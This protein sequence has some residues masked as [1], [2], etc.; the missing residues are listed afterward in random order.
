MDLRGD[1]GEHGRME[2][3]VGGG[4]TLYNG[5]SLDGGSGV[6]VVM[7]DTAGRMQNNKALMADLQTLVQE[8]SPHLILYVIEALVGN[9]GID[10]IQYFTKVLSSVKGD[11]KEG[12]I[13]T[14]FDTVN[15]K[16]GA[17]LSGLVCL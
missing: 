7:I 8:G 10:Q 16:V 6:D 12:I 3:E 4:F 5:R 14:K 1:G 11:S 2:E 9:D 13:L 15:D 17:A